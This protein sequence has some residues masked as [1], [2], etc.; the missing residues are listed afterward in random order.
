M[1]TLLMTYKIGKIPEI[2]KKKKLFTKILIK[3]LN[4][5]K[6]DPIDTDPFTA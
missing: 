5:I 2:T 6:G 3:Y 1:K 4:L